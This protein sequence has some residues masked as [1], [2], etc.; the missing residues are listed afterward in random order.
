MRNEIKKRVQ[1]VLKNK[2]DQYWLQRITDS[3]YNIGILLK[4]Y[5]IP[6]NISHQLIKSDELFVIAEEELNFKHAYE[7]IQKYSENPPPVTVIEYN[8]IKY[9]FMG[10]VRA[11][12]Y[13]LSGDHINC[14]VVKLNEVMNSNFL[15]SANKTLKAFI[16]EYK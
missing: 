6:N 13:G 14:V 10:S 16:E 15:L 12:M 4:T 8:G 2:I 5:I 1:L 7:C 9:L 3:I 11:L